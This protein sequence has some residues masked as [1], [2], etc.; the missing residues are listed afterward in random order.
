M[1]HPALRLALTSEHTNGAPWP[2][3]ASAGCPVLRTPSRPGTSGC[4]ARTPGSAFVLRLDVPLDLEPPDPFRSYQAHRQSPAILGSFSSPPEVRPLP[5]TGISGF[6]GTTGLSDARTGRHP[7]RASGTRPRPL[8]A[9][10]VSQRTFRACCSHYHGGPR[11]ARSVET[12][13]RIAAF[14]DSQAGRRP[15]LVL[16]WPAQDSHALRPARWRSR[17]SRDL[18]PR[19]RHGPLPGRSAWVATEVNRKLLGRNSHPLVL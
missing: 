1:P 10:H 4:L 3:H 12:P 11:R 16:S 6:S 13:R 9:S 19:L 15:Q 5:S 14:P 18:T 8:R 17:L 7:Q 2:A